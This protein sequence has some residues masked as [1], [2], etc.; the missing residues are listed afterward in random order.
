MTQE[1]VMW[2]R[3]YAEAV[4]DEKLRLLAY[5]DRWHFVAILC[6]QAQG[7]L[8]PGDTLMWRKV[9][10]KLG[11]QTRELEEVARRLAEVGLIDP[12]T[13]HPLAWEKRQYKT[14]ISTDRVRAYRERKRSETLQKR[15]VTVSETPPDTDT[16]TDMNTA[17]AVLVDSP[18]NAGTDDDPAGR[19][20]HQKIIALYHRHL[21]TCPQVRSWQGQRPRLLTARW[22]E[23][24][25]LAWW[26]GFLTFCGESP[27]LNGRVN[28]SKDRPP[29]FATLEWICRPQNFQRIN[30]GQYHR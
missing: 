5:E 22:R 10:V 6:C 12:Q 18:A 14:D 19:C 8:D 17:K 24:P 26:E 2:F 23:H 21:P 7:L 16:E 13:L 25:D 30:E 27:F 4:D 1:Q 9:A 11:L 20:P 15:S 28:G 29:F 3:F